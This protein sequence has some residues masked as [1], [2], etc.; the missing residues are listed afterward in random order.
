MDEIDLKILKI[1]QKN[2]KYSLED[3]SAE[4]KIPKSTV[5]YR[6]K[7]LEALNIIKGYYAQIDPTALNLDYIVISLVRAR[8]G[9]NYH[10]ELGSKLASLPGV[11][12]VYFVLG[13]IDFIVVGRYR[14]REEFVENYL[15]KLMSMPEIERS[16]TQVVVKIIKE[17]PNMIIW[18]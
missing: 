8:Y 13:D 10:T 3:L 15:E 5:A 14:N 12:G 9:K 6:I 1:L 7:R 2:A 18:W 16:S 17:S 11:W 4:L